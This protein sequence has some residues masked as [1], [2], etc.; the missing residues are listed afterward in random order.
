MWSIR[1]GSCTPCSSAS[2]RCS[3]RFRR[4]CS[5]DTDDCA[6]CAACGLRANAGDGCHY[7]VRRGEFCRGSPTF[8]PGSGQL[9]PTRFIRLKALRV[10]RSGAPMSSTRVEVGMSVVLADDRA[11]PDSL[12][13]YEPPRYRRGA[14]DGGIRRVLERLSRGERAVEHS[15]PLLPDMID[16]ERSP[17]DLAPL[18]PDPFSVIGK[19]VTLAACVAVLTAPGLYYF[20]SGGELHISAHGISTRPPARRVTEQPVSSP[21]LKAISV[22]AVVIAPERDEP[23][24]E[25]A[26]RQ[27][28]TTIEKVAVVERAEEPI[29]EEATAPSETELALLSPLKS[30]L[31]FPARQTA[32][33]RPDRRNLPRLTRTRRARNRR[34]V[35]SPAPIT[36]ASNKCAACGFTGRRLL[37][38]Q[39]RSADGPVQSIPGRVT[40]VLRG[41]TTG[42][43]KT[44]ARAMKPAPSE[45][46]LRSSTGSAETARTAAAA[47]AGRAAGSGDRAGLHRKRPSRC[48]FLRASLR[49]RRIASAFSRAFFSDG[50]S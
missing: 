1:S 42:R 45:N 31:M 34:G 33:T 30:W 7:F 32:Q 39:Q 49:A 20:A 8:P 48:I 3:C 50:F 18:T 14:A 36:N 6:Q 35:S 19:A 17:P 4:W 27:P 43:P 46:L 38:A 26:D 15:P 44:R 10:R 16:D 22:K 28:I 9:T 21:D 24:A 29:A 2:R 37:R 47:A 25:K 23:F 41:R 13:Y 5:A 11:N 40:E 12:R